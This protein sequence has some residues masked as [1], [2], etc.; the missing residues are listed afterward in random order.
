MFNL[1]L[2]PPIFNADRSGVNSTGQITI[3]AT[4]SGRCCR[5]RGVAW[6]GGVPNADEMV[7]LMMGVAGIGYF[8]LR[9]HDEAKTP[10]ILMVR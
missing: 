6:P 10:S 7:G 1:Q 4:P 9:L 8:Y 5:R 3:L 2:P